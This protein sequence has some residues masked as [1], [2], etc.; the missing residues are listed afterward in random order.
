M[1]GLTSRSQQAMLRREFRTQ[2]HIRVHRTGSDLVQPYR[3]I[4]NAV[5]QFGTRLVEGEQTH[6]IAERRAYNA[7][8]MRETQLLNE[9]FTH[10]RLVDEMGEPIRVPM[11]AMIRRYLILVFTLRLS[12]RSTAGSIIRTHHD[13]GTISAIRAS[14]LAGSGPVHILRDHYMLRF[15]TANSASAAATCCSRRNVMYQFVVPR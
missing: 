15:A 14:G 3:R 8:V 6:A 2:H 4:C 11:D 10:V 13:Y 12:T 7:S 1:T 5:I 9:A